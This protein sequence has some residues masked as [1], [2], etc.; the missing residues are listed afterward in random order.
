MPSYYFAGEDDGLA[1]ERRVERDLER[2]P[3]RYVQRRPDPAPRFVKACE[4]PECTGLRVVAAGVVQPP[5]KTG[6]GQ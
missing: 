1:L 5:V 4:C 3:R 6:G 2:E